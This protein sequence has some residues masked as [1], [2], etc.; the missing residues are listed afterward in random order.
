M[1]LT[2][3]TPFL[4]A[5]AAAACVLHA[6]VPATS[7]SSAGT[8]GQRYGELSFTAQNITHVSNDATSLDFGVNCPIAKH[9][10]LGGSYTYGWFHNNYH[11]RSSILDTGATVYATYAGIKPFASLNLG[12]EWDRFTETGFYPYHANYGVWGLGV[13]VEIPVKPTVA[14]T[15]FI[16]YQDDFQDSAHSAQA[17]DFGV[18]VNYWF[19]KAWAVFADGGYQ[20]VLHSRYNSWVWSIG[21]RQK[22]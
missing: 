18:E 22:F 21:L 6:D 19:R 5:T 11:Q 16:S 3:I 2:K 13:G 14:I 12:Y 7:D 8:L 4:L 17:Y 20:A 15:P 9:I 10:D 1:N